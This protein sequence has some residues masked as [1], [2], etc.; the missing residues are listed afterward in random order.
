MMNLSGLTP[1]A[2]CGSKQVVE[3]SPDGNKTVSSY[4]VDRQGKLDGKST[5]Y[6]DSGRVRE[7]AEY[8]HGMRHGLYVKYHENGELFLKAEFDNERLMN[9]LEYR[10]S[11][12]TAFPVGTLSN[13]NGTV[14]IYYKGTGNI[15]ETG[16]VR[17]GLREGRWVTTM[18][19]GDVFVETYKEGRLGNEQRIRSIVW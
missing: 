1:F 12:G 5:E 4:S 9:I 11:N 7:E 2:G 16:E 3:M 18:S 6:F 10:D 19:N 8:H 13:G 17:N 15:V 14:N